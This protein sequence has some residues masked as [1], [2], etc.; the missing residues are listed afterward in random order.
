MFN[1]LLEVSFLTASKGN[2]YVGSK[3]VATGV[4]SRRQLLLVSGSTPVAGIAVTV[5]LHLC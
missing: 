2:S 3:P 1:E 5:E 4:V